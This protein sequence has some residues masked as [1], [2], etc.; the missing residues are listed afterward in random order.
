MLQ[1][2]VS[3]WFLFCFWPLYMFSFSFCYW[4]FL[5]DDQIAKFLRYF[6]CAIPTC[7]TPNILLLHNCRKGMTW[8]LFVVVSVNS[9][10]CFHCIKN[11]LKTADRSSPEETSL[12]PPSS[13]YRNIHL[14][15]EYYYYVSK[16]SC[17]NSPII[18]FLNGPNCAQVLN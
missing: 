17:Q 11:L 16:L 6:Q 3:V 5:A 8:L 12:P 7:Y 14:Q 2:L 4:I 9:L 18:F 10:N 15:R 1:V 13:L